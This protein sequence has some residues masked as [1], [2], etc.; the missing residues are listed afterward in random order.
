LRLRERLNPGRA[1]GA[2]ATTLMLLHRRRE[3]KRGL[4]P[5]R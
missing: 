5:N 4:R 1:G 3:A 2:P